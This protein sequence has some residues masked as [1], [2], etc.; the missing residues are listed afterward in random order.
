MTASPSTQEKYKEA[1]ETARFYAECIVNVRALTIAEGLAVVGAAGYLSKDGLHAYASAVAVFGLLLTYV[2]YAFH[3]SYVAYFSALLKYIVQ[4][5]NGVGPWSEYNRER[6]VMRKSILYRLTHLY[7]AI[8][9]IAVTL[10]VLIVWNVAC[11][12]AK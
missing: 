6:D 9:V 2:L 1:C 11:L 5:E 8:T 12:A 4:T 7:G 10:A 3:R